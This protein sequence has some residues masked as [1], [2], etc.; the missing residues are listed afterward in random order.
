MGRNGRD[1]DALASDATLSVGD[2]QRGARTEERPSV[3]G[4]AEPR[5][6]S[7]RRRLLRVVSRPRTRIGRPTRLTPRLAKALVK[8]IAQTG[9]I[10]PA[11]RRCGVPH[12]TVCDWIARGEGR[13]R[14]GRRACSP[15]VEFAAA[16]QKALGQ[17]ESDQLAGI[18]AAAAAKPENWTAR[19][20]QLER[21][22]PQRYGRRT[23]VEH[24][25][26]I[27]VMEVR[28]LL[29]AMI[30]VLERYVPLER[31]ETELANLLAE[32]RELGGGSVVALPPPRES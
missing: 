16:V 17:Y 22:D 30:G 14:E 1:N 27:T 23:A 29:L 31:R 15:Y 3:V 7:G 19:A 24:T 21:W 13:H 26:T 6:A 2:D 11:A 8:L 10:E 18:Q 5:P 20:W 32:A 28:G 4:D 9:R 12:Q 25:G